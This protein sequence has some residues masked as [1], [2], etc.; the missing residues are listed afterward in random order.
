MSQVTSEMGAEELLAFTQR[1]LAK[2]QFNCRSKGMYSRARV[3]A[4]LL[5]LQTHMPALAKRGATS[6]EQDSYMRCG[7]A[8]PKQYDASLV[9]PSIFTPIT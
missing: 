2:F 5:L 3:S 9:S 4:E 8:L 6:P 7:I 1:V